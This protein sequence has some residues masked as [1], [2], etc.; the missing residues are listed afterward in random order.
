V[1]VLLE[2]IAQLGSAITSGLGDRRCVVHVW[3][4]NGVRS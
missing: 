3:M 2:G 1:G 4:T